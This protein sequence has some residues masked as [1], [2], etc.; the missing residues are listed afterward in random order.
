MT[1]GSVQ[2]D[3]GADSP[4]VGRDSVFEELLDILRA[5]R[6]GKVVTA[7]LTGP[8]GSGTTAVLES[9]LEY[10]RTGVRGG[11][12]RSA[13]GTQCLARHARR[14]H[15]EGVACDRISARGT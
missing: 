14:P 13:A 12:A 9:F 2:G 6:K 15:D 8:A 10:C 5:V 1:A 3:I 4:L 7:V 11:R